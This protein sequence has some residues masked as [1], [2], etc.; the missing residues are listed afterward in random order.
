MMNH[1]HRNLAPIA[2]A[3][4]AAIDQE[5]EARLRTHL[6]A[7]RLVDFVGP[8]GWSHSATDLGR[9]W[10][11]PGPSEGITAAQRRVLPLVELREP[12]VCLSFRPPN[13]S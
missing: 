10:T 13:G 12:R 9:I 11:I 2:S 1:L 4:W 6:A 3:G 5:A 8:N 7:R